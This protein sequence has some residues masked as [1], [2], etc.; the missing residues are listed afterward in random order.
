M[1]ALT[2]TPGAGPWEIDLTHFPRPPTPICRDLYVRVFPVGLAVGMAEMGLL[3]ETLQLRSSDQGFIYTQPKLVAA[4]AGAPPP[5]GFVLWLLS[6]LHPALRARNR[7]VGE[8]MAARTWRREAEVFSAE[9][10]PELNRRHRA[11]LAEDPA[12]MDDRALLGHLDR[13]HEAFERAVWIHGRYTA[14]TQLPIGDLIAHVRDWSGIPASEVMR[15]VAGHAPSSGGRSPELDALVAALR[16]HPGVLPADPDAEPGDVLAALQAAPAPVGPLARA[17]VEVVGHRVVAAY[18]VAEPTAVEFPFLLVSSLRAALEGRL[19]AARTDERAEAAL[20][21]RIPPAHRSAFDSLLAEAR[22]M[23][24]LRDERCL[25]ADY[26]AAGILRRALLEAGRRLAARGLIPTAEHLCFATM[27]EVRGLMSGESPPLGQVLVDRVGQRQPTEPP[28]A[29]FGQL[30]PPPS[31]DL[32]LAPTACVLRAVFAVLEGM[33][34]DCQEKP[35]NPDAVQGFPVSA[36]AY[37]GVVRIVKGPEDFHRI[38]P[39]DVLVA[40]MTSPVY[41]VV[42][43]LLGAVVTDRGGALSHAAIV[44]REFGIPGVVGCRNATQKLRDGAR[45]RV[46][47]TSGRVTL[48]VA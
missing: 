45:V 36:G 30:H 11:L 3:L 34:Q 8:V 37:E 25:Y 47:G 39:G 43:P 9:V 20:R 14:A 24:H 17:W 35:E 38:R 1:N 31:L 46:D 16:E 12:A 6:R 22:A 27:D 26:W 28:P 4:P 42:L 23:S 2:Q 33:F 13:C 19:G 18:D 15:L 29:L 7:R 10:R 48:A 32:F 5:P 21:E 40:A 41:N 44:S